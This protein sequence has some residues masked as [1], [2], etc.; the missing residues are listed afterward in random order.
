MLSIIMRTPITAFALLLFFT[1]SSCG[2]S[3]VDQC[4]AL[5]SVGTPKTSEKPSYEELLASQ[6]ITL[7]GYKKLRL[8]DQD[9]KKFRGKRVN[10]SEQQVSLFQQ[11]IEFEKKPKNAESHQQ[12]MSQ[13]EKQIEIAEQFLTLSKES[14][15]LCP[16]GK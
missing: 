10:L 7:E 16:L 3:R 9:L 4:N 15:K 8:N 1:L 11:L 2:M 6:K 12:A 5:M 13:F 14:N